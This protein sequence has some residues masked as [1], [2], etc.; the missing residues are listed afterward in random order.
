MKKPKPVYPASP[1]LAPSVTLKHALAHWL[2]CG[3]EEA[4]HIGYGNDAGFDGRIRRSK[5]RNT[6]FN[7]WDSSLYR[8]K[9]PW[10]ETA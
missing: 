7:D 5:V 9:V 1:L 10:K 2:R 8:Q 4:L 3:R 6:T